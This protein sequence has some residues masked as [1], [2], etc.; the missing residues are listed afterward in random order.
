M[1]PTTRVRASLVVGV[2][3]ALAAGAAT[4][5][6]V[7]DS[8]RDA[9]AA[10]GCPPGSVPVDLTLP[11]D[12]GQVTLRILN[13]TRTAGVADAVSADFRDRGFRA[14]AAGQSGSRVAGA[15]IVR[16]GPRGVGAAQLVR[17]YFL[18]AAEPVFD[19]ARTTG[20]IDVVVGEQFRQ[21]PTKTEVNQSLAQ[22]STPTPPPGTCA[23]GR[24]LDDQ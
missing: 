10:G 11:G 16:Y 15:G 12:A 18:G 13:G 5:T 6:L 19:R 8:Q 7:R 3:A 21:L 23:D 4:V 9:A 24:G 17:A 20:A 22:L 1:A 2:L 14:E